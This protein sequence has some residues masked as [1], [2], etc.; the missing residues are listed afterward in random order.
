[1][2]YFK[3]FHCSFHPYIFFNKDH[4]SL[5]F[6]GF[7][8]NDKG[9]LID[10]ATKRIIRRRLFTHRLLQGLTAQKVTFNSDGSHDQ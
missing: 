6:I 10:P 4:D 9:D 3:I 1:M 8:V 5:T 7:N 2:C